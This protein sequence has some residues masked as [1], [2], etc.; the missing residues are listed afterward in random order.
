LA[1]LGEQRE[2][3]TGR[4]GPDYGDAHFMT[5]SYFTLDPPG[6]AYDRVIVHETPPGAGLPTI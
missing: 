6:P 5:A 4:S 1:A 3:E 2:Q